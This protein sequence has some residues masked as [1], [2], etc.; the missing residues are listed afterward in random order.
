VTSLV[1]NTP[2]SATLPRHMV[3]F[4]R[5]RLSF[6]QS[7]SPCPSTDSMPI[8]PRSTPLRFLMCLCCTL[9]A[10]RCAAAELAT[11]G[12]GDLAID[13]CHLKLGRDHVRTFWRDPSGV[14]F[15]NFDRLSAWLA[16]RGETLV[17]ATNAGIYGQDLRP[18]GLYVEAGQL[19]R[20]LNVRKRAYGNFYLQPNGALLLSD[21]EAKI[22]STDEISADTEKQLSTIRYATQS[23]PIMLRNT[24]INPLFTPGSENRVV[25][26]AVCVITSTEV[27]LARSR[28][29]INF[30]DFA[31]Q[32]REKIGC[33]DALYLDGSISQLYPF[34]K[35]SFGPD[36][37]TMIGAT[38]STRP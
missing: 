7:K 37:A 12:T 30:H 10:F 9:L 35:N 2:A 1:P 28:A 14:V 33:R 26:N 21:K 8:K 17:C 4:N 20:K 3:R 27:V 5:E 38:I 29:P 16:T 15:G 25:R 6:H 18:I 36:F 11:H 32:L 34:G 22:L 19:R 31:Q 13:A 24:K 23:G